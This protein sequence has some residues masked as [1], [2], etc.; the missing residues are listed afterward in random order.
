MTRQFR[1][2]QPKK[3]FCSISVTDDGIRR[4]EIPHS[5]NAQAQIRL[6][7]ESKTISERVGKK[8]NES[9]PMIVTDSQNDTSPIG[10]PRNN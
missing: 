6:I 2:L 5:A 3:A 1:P 10:H 7:G 4:I 9:R 8:Q